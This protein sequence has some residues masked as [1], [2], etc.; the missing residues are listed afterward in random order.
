MAFIRMIRNR[1]TS[2]NVDCDVTWVDS[3]F[4]FP[5]FGVLTPTTEQA[6]WLHPEVSNWLFL[7]IH[8]CKLISGFSSIFR[9]FQL[10]LFL[11]F[12]QSCGPPV[13]I[14]LESAH[15]EG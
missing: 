4:Q 10:L 6:R 15:R 8:Q 12:Y 14:S 1:S 11:H 2:A 7:S 5:H 9:F 3:R 13:M